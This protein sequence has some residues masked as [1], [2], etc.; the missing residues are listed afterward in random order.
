MICTPLGTMILIGLGLMLLA[1]GLPPL[2]QIAW[3]AARHARQRRRV[4]PVGRLAR[5]N[6]RLLAATGTLT[7]PS[8]SRLFALPSEEITQIK[9]PLRH[10]RKQQFYS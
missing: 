2:L 7:G 6:V 3:E 8:T 5:P 1:V 9:H 10:M 4:A